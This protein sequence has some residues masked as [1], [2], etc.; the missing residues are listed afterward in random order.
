MA[1]RSSGAGTAT[2][3][4][5]F[6]RPNNS[7]GDGE[8]NNSATTMFTAATTRERLKITYTKHSLVVVAAA[9]AAAMTEFTAAVNGE[10]NMNIVYVR[11]SLY[12]CP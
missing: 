1:W 5:Q 3:H 6:T 10:K 7:N 2:V 8:K 12:T 11:C 4:G 9:A